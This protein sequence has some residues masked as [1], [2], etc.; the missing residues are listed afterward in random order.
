MN[1]INKS[2]RTPS[3]HPIKN[4]VE[5]GYCQWES[6][7]NIALVK[8]W[9]KRHEQIPCN[10]SISFTLN[11]A[12]TITTL[13]WTQKKNISNDIIEFD[14]LFEEKR[15]I[16]FSNRIEKILNRLAVEVPLL[17]EYYLTITSENTFP[18]S[19]G[20][21][22]SASAMS[23]LAAAVVDMEEQILGKPHLNLENNMKAKYRI[24]NFSRLGSGSAC[25]SIFPH[26]ALWGKCS[27]ANSNDKYAIGLESILHSDFKN[28]KD[29][30]L[31][32]DQSEK[33][34]SSSIGHQLMD[35]NPYATVRYD[36]ARKNT[37]KLLS[38][39]QTGDLDDF[40]KLVEEEAMMLHALMMTSSPGYI[41]MHPNTLQ[42][43]NKIQ[44]FRHETNTPVC[45]T[46]DAGPNVHLLYPDQST[47]IV[48]EFIHSE[49]LPHCDNRNWIP[50]G[51]G[52]G[53]KKVRQ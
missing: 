49:L 4:T 9:G 31:L 37:E 5:S 19:S 14:F 22:S 30:I 6:P 53:P 33:K 3:A 51:M 8:Y 36:Q 11:N 44:S 12:H 2:P 40:T 28:F 34:V 18:H 13:E 48:E 46:L 21:A 32:V 38:I 39:L 17:K 27:Y 10:P 23:A 24:S 41:L 26:A 16:S 43:I 35:Q 29:A 25:R 7:S 20:I 1:E 50:D 42:I 15:H 47:A 52:S 45:F